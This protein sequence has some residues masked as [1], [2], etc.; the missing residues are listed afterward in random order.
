MS[1]NN[2]F[3]IVRDFFNKTENDSHEFKSL[4]TEIEEEPLNP[5]GGAVFWLVISF[6]AAAICWMYFGKVDVVITAPGI[7][8][9]SGQEKVVKA[10][11]KGVIY[12]INA[13]EGEYVKKGQTLVIIKPAEAE[14]GLELNNLREE[15]AINQEKLESAKYRLSAALDKK[16]RLQSVIDIIPKIQYDEANQEAVLAMHE[17][18]GCEAVLKELK[19]KKEQIQK[20]I[21]TIK[22]PIDGYVNSVKIHTLGGVVA[23]AEE[24]MTIV[25]KDAPLEIKAKV[26]NQDIGFVKENIPV[27]VKLDTFNFQKY[28]YLNGIVSVVSPNSIMDEKMGAVYEVYITLENTHLMVE[29]R[30]ETAKAGM[31]TINEIKIGK[32]RIIEFFIYPLVKYLDESI[33]VR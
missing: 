7:V 2:I 9:P 32:R 20:Q 11:E 27:T 4:L 1:L 26:F 24:L 23:P 5:L 25:P 19:N 8:I 3:K 30:D 16:Q 31:T 15:T 21:Q 13:K 17:I 14:P 29:G 10:L 22:S 33:K 18:K 28:G 12:S 6:I